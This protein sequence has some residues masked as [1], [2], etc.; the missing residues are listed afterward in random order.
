MSFCCLG[1]QGL[2]YRKVDGAGV[3]CGTGKGEILELQLSINLLGVSRL[4]LELPGPNDFYSNRNH[5]V[6]G[7]QVLVAAWKEAYF[8]IASL[9]GQSN[10]K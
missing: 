7:V 6:L 10:N 2:V 5:L 1:R 3:K 9:F 8:Q 4:N